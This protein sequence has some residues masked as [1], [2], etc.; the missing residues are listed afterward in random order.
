MKLLVDMDITVT[1]ACI[2]QEHRRKKHCVL[3]ILKWSAGG[4][5][6]VAYLTPCLI[7]AA[8]SLRRVCLLAP[9]SRP[10]LVALLFFSSSGLSLLL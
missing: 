9:H 3:C 5:N 10:G 8:L 4:R 2:S 6:P 7:S 1:V